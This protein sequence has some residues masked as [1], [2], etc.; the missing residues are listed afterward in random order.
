MGIGGGA[1]LIVLLLL[2]AMYKAISWGVSGAVSDNNPLSVFMP[3]ADRKSD[4]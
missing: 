1:A 3:Y 2:N 4:V